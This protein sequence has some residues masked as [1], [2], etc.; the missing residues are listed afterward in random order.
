MSRL[1]WPGTALYASLALLFVLTYLGGTHGPGIIRILFVVGCLAVSH[2]A[3]RLGPAFHFEALIVLFSCSPYLRRIVD[4]HSGYDPHGLMLIGPLVAV[5]LPT[6]RLPAALLQRRGAIAGQAGTFLLLAL[7]LCYAALL[8]VMQGNYMPAAI[9]LVK[10]LSVLAY[11]YWLIADADPRQVMRQAGRA[12]AIILPVI[13]IYGLMQYLDP[14]PADRYWMIASQESSM[15]NPEPLEVRVFSM[16]NSPQSFGDFVIVGLMIL[17]YLRRSWEVLVL[18]AP[19]AIALLL[20]QARAAW[21]ALA[22]AILYTFSFSG[23]KARS[24]IVVA[25][26]VI[27]GGFAIEATPLGDVISTRLETM[28]NNPGQDGSAQA[29]LEDLRFLFDHLDSYIVGAGFS[30]PGGTGLAYSTQ[31][32]RANDGIIIQS[33]TSMGAVVGVLFIVGVLWAGLHAA[34]QVKSRAEPEFVIAASLTIGQ[35]VVLPLNNPAVGEVGI[36][37]WSMIAVATR[38]PGRQGAGSAG[39]PPRIPRFG[40]DVMQAEPGSPVAR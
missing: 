23:T 30:A 8:S 9:G 25:W 20:S 40:A 4:F 6:M 34:A 10:T 33:V 21:I 16:L 19:A 12:F 22:V 11:G 13:G 17:G 7:C 29:R 24:T 38:A 3:L 1:R 39:S 15:G 26:I 32:L 35:L 18:S 36:L 2:L 14:S 37:F 27:A 28:T 31:Q 5:L